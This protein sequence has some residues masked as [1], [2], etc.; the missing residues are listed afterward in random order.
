M[1]SDLRELEA[2]VRLLERARRWVEEL[3]RS[4]EESEAMTNTQKIEELLEQILSLLREIK[5][6]LPLRSDPAAAGPAATPE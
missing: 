1:N 4:E 5:A 2:R 3:T 6:A